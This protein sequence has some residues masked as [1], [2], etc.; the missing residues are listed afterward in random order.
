MKHENM[1]LITNGKHKH[2]FLNVWLLLTNGTKNPGFLSLISRIVCFGNYTSMAVFLFFECLG[3]SCA[4]T[5]CT[6]P[7]SMF[8]PH[9]AIDWSI[10]R[11]KSIGKIDEFYSRV[12]WAPLKQ[13]GTL[14]V[15]CADRYLTE[16]EQGSCFVLPRLLQILSLE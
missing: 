1:N 10:R 9:Y 3:P 13:A 6:A 4:D 12:K 5:I 16:I 8:D 2:R 15:G 11:K 7:N 14:Q